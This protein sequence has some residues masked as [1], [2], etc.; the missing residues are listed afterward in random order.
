MKTWRTIAG[1]ELAVHYMLTYEY[2][3]NAADKRTPFRAMHLSLLRD[4]HEDGLVLMA[5]AWADPLDGAA[6]VFNVEQRATVE[7][8]VKED[9]YVANGIVRS[10]QIREWSVAIGA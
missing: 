9:P 2:T 10:W 1:E 3:D 5:G 7:S 6:I 8:F 4:L